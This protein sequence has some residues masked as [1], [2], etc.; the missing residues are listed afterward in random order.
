MSNNLPVVLLVEDEAAIS[1]LLQDV[2]EEAGYAVAGPF[3]TCARAL[4]WLETE[5]PDRAVLDTILLDGSCKDLAAELIRRKVPFLVFSGTPKRD[6]PADEFQDAV[7]IEK[8]APLP[9]L[10]EALEGLRPEAMRREA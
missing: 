2:M 9:T 7:W 3:A 5:T 6:N 4:T 1:M 10:L 8:P